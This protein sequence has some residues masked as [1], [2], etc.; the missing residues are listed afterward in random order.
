[1][2][3]FNVNTN[4]VYLSENAIFCFSTIT[5]F[6]TNFL[7]LRQMTP[8]V[9]RSVLNKPFEYECMGS[10]DDKISELVVSKVHI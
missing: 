8:P 9:H 6:G 3:Y 4:D 1:M 5:F 7:D 10:L 2:A